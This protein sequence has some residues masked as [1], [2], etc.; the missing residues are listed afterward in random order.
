MGINKKY[1]LEEV[2]NKVKKVYLAIN[3]DKVDVKNKKYNDVNNIY[4][5]NFIGFR[6]II[7]F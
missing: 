4:K 5:Y 6:N 7:L 3:N 1:N 2:G